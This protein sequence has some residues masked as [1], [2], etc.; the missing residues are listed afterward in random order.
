[1]CRARSFRFSRN[2]RR[3]LLN[4]GRPSM[5]SRSRIS[6]ARGADD[7]ADVVETEQTAGEDV[8]PLVVLAVHPPGEVE[9]KLLEDSRE[10]QA[11]PLTACPGHLVDPPRR[12]GVH[13]RIDVAERELVGGD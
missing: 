10:K 7:D 3:R 5:T 6:Q 13:G 12:P 2:Q 9:E 1:M 11:V 4:P 8:L